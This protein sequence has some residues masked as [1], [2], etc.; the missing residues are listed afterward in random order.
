MPKNNNENKTVVKKNNKGKIPVTQDNIETYNKVKA[1]YQLSQETKAFVSKKLSD[2]KHNLAK[3]SLG[4]RRPLG[5]TIVAKPLNFK[6]LK[7]AAAE[8]RLNNLRQSVAPN[9]NETVNQ[10]PAV[11]NEVKPTRVIKIKEPPRVKD[12]IKAF[13]E[14][15]PKKT[16]KKSLFDIDEEE[17]DDM[18]KEDQGVKNKGNKFD[19]DK[20][21]SNR[22]KDIFG[23]TEEDGHMFEDAYEREE[24]LE[25]ERLEQLSKQNGE[26]VKPKTSDPAKTTKKAENKKPKGRLDHLFGDDDEPEAEA[27]TVDQ[28]QQTVP[29]QPETQSV[30]N[31]QPKPAIPKN[32]PKNQNNPKDKFNGLF[33]MDDDEPELEANT[34]SQSQQTAPQQPAIKQETENVQNDQSEPAK[35][36]NGKQKFDPDKKIANAMKDLLGVTEEDGHMFE[37]VEER[38]QRTE[39]NNN[40]GRI[41]D[42]TNIQQLRELMG[43]ADDVDGNQLNTDINGNVIAGN[44]Q[45]E[46]KYVVNP[47][48]RHINASFEI[49]NFYS[50]FESHINNPQLAIDVKAEL[51]SIANAAGITDP[52][53]CSELVDSTY[54]SAITDARNQWSK[55]AIYAPISDVAELQFRF[56]LSYVKDASPNMSIKDQ[57]ITAQK[58]ANVAVK[59]YTPVA[60]ADHKL[61]PYADNFVMKHDDLFEHALKEQEVPEKQ[62]PAIMQDVRT[63]LNINVK[64]DAPE[65]VANNESQPQPQPEVQPEAVAPIQIDNFHNRLQERIDN[66]KL[67]KEVKAELRSIVEEAGIED[68]RTVSDIVKFAYESTMHDVTTQYA[69]GS[70]RLKTRQI[71]KMYYD[72]SFVALH[73]AD[74]S[75]KVRMITAQKMA[76][77]MVKNYSTVT[78]ADHKMDQYADNYVL[79]DDEFLRGELKD[80]EVPEDKMDEMMQDIRASLDGDLVI[81]Q[82]A[83]E[84]APNNEVQPQPQ[85][86]PEDNSRPQFIPWDQRKKS[87]VGGDDDEDAE[88]EF[89][90]NLNALTNK[91]KPKEPPKEKTTEEKYK[92]IRAN[93]LTSNTDTAD[94]ANQEFKMPETKPKKKAPL[95]DDLDDDPDYELPYVN[96]LDH[97]TKTVKPK[98]PPKEK[99]TEEKY[100]DLRANVLISNP[101]T[102]DL[103]DQEFKM[104]ETQ[105]K[106]KSIFGQE[107]EDD[108]DAEI[109]YVNNLD[110]LTKNVKPKEPPK[111]KTTAEKLDNLRNEVF[112]ANNVQDNIDEQEEQKD[113]KTPENNATEN[114]KAKDEKMLLGMA[115]ESVEAINEKKDNAA[116]VKVFTE[117]VDTFNKM[118]K[119][120]ID[121][122]NLSIS[123]TA[124]YARMNSGDKDK[125]ADGKK[126][127]GSAFKTT[128]KDALQNEKSLAYD[129]QRLPDYTEII[130]SANELM[131]AA[132]F[133]YTDLYRGTGKEEIFGATAFGGLDAKEM[134][135]LTTGDSLWKMD[136]KSDKAWEIQS[137]PAKALADKWLKEKEPYEKMIDEMNALIEAKKKGTVDNK[138]AYNK[139]AAAEWL[140]LNNDKMM[141]ENPE[142]PLNKMPKW[143]TRY[144]QSITKAREALGVPKHISMRD[145]IQ[146]DY[147]EMAKSTNSV[148]YN[149][150]VINEQILDPKQRAV[151]D[152]MDK[153]KEV[154]TIQRE[155]IATKDPANEEKILNAEMNSVKVRISI[156]EENEYKKARTG[157]KNMNFITEKEPEKNL[158]SQKQESKI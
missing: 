4:R 123:I 40:V 9:T 110:H 125:K 116:N 41:Q 133:A 94:L 60:L 17:L 83:P 153:Q 30:Q 131:R 63:A 128:L 55:T 42:A 101:D 71:A 122:K 149:E 35:N 143:G 121:A 70:A 22:M 43:N 145:L 8:T 45:P 6:S 34:V 2:I 152:S 10:N 27:D 51:R 109:E 155:N 28:I 90:S 29:K 21:I 69:E 14:N 31:E 92:D 39:T 53:K 102:A 89:V 72:D 156:E 12:D 130:K 37:D 24:R 46:E 75:D 56:L 77:V 107:P 87:L 7:K 111:E 65:N 144:W 105:P 47:D 114:D 84:N 106:K 78:F 62:I 139:F 96:N 32:P 97:L 126:M 57:V 124:S 120:N 5:A 48:E 141:M 15:Q 66:A 20:K 88:L 137:S 157:L 140:L 104:P 135:S 151:H 16:N 13:E 81:E 18:R 49:N 129:E 3:R 150:S 119:T 36:N 19:A 26:D 142:D 11:T 127:L 117:K 1:A 146:G 103:A 147:A 108:P 25:R 148:A 59:N 68:E 61:D 58:M 76:N 112:I 86:Q 44:D 73:E 100:K 118:Y 23:T 136:Q 52:E 85:P 33:K 99:T 95:G 54:D 154:F 64:Q 82:P 79:K 134:A 80:L 113:E 38:E 138:D 50:R 158:N 74:M 98:E 132:M 93:A 115:T 67:T 91:S